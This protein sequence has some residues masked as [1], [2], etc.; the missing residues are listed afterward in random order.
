MLLDF[1]LGFYMRE[2]EVAASCRDQLACIGCKL[3]DALPPRL[4]FS[5]SSRIDRRI[6][7]Q[8]LRAGRRPNG[9]AVIGV[10]QMQQNL[11]CH[12]VIGIVRQGL[13]FVVP[14]PARAAKYAR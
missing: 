2:I 9:C 7:R 5:R 13:R 14:V 12:R 6:F 8:V 11:S 1:E 4:G 3:P 10:D